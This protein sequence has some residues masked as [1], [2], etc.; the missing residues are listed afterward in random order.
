VT[1]SCRRERTT[2]PSSAERS[3]GLIG[4]GPCLAQLFRD[5]LCRQV[6]KV[7]R[8]AKPSDLPIEQP[9]KF[10]LVVN[11]ETAKAMAHEIPA[12]LV[13]RADKVIE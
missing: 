3:D 4:Y 8:G 7:L 13:L 2:L 5:L 10:E 1:L 11:L 6:V 9:T 12:A